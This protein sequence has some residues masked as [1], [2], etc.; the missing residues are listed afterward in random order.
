MCCIP[1]GQQVGPYILGADRV[2]LCYLELL[3]LVLPADGHSE[4][5]PNDEPQQGQR[6]RP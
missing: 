6:G 4:A 2:G 3:A 5:E 1:A